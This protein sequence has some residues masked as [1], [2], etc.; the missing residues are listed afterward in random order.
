MKRSKKRYKSV[1]FIETNTVPCV[2]SLCYFFQMP[3]FIFD[4]LSST[5]LAADKQ[6]MKDSKF[7]LTFWLNLHSPHVKTHVLPS[8][9]WYLPPFSR[10]M[11]STWCWSKPAMPGRNRWNNMAR[12][13]RSIDVSKYVQF[14]RLSCNIPTLFYWGRKGELYTSYHIRLIS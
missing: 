6:C 9:D 1:V 8:T 13:E 7:G 5:P 12:R 14:F 4:L 2:F 11:K 10:Q 3:C